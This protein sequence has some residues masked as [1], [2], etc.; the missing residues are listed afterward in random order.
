MYLLGSFQIV[1]ALK[2][3]PFHSPSEF[4]AHAACPWSPAQSLP[5]YGWK[6]VGPLVLWGCTGLSPGPHPGLRSEEWNRPLLSRGPSTNKLVSGAQGLW[7]SE[8]SRER[9]LACPPLPPS[10]AAS[11]RQPP[12]RTSP[13]PRSSPVP[14]SRP[15]HCPQLL[16]GVSGSES[17]FR[18]SSHPPA[19]R[20]CL[21]AWTGHMEL[22]S[23][24][25]QTCGCLPHPPWWGK[26]G[27]QPLPAPSPGSQ[28]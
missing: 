2:S 1:S 19:P 23:P 10:P 28:A 27:P 13:F 3:P 6:R 11:F 8:R 15:P 25:L 12:N 5:L 20:P 26:A 18:S 7:K 9:I 21:S 14:H 24:S 16:P 22:P 17:Y 4:T